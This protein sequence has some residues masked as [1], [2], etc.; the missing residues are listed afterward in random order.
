MRD[1]D[2]VSRALPPHPPWRD[3][4]DIFAVRRKPRHHVLRKML[5]LSGHRLLTFPASFQPE[6][7][8]FPPALTFTV[9]FAATTTCPDHTIA[10]RFFTLI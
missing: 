7:L 10:P 2:H 3:P 8:R 9:W 1:D 6:E 4:A 5:A